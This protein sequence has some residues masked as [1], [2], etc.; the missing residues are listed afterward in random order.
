MLRVGAHECTSTY[1][2]STRAYTG[3]SSETLR[4]QEGGYP[5]IHRVGRAPII[6]VVKMAD[7]D[8]DWGMYKIVNPHSFHA[9]SEISLC[10]L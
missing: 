1:F 9:K 10:I 5:I 3:T 7:E 2:A 8:F 4:E 6:L